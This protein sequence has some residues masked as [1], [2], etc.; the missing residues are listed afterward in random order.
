MTE[1]ENEL[2]YTVT[3]LIAAPAK[4]AF[5]FLADVT[6]IGGWALGAFDAKPLSTPGVHAGTSLYD[7]S[8]CAFAVDADERRLLVDYLVGSNAK[9]L[10]M[11]I[12][13]RIIPGAASGR[14]A[15]S[16]LVSMAAW[17]PDGFDERR[18]A[19]LK[20]FHDAEIHIVRDRVEK[21]WGK[22]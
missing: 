12:A 20:A 21:A 3:S 5:A 15:D 1:N 7:G 22:R 11:R 13:I 2:C 14:D 8:D 18:W 6:K 16:C 10:V 9:D 19:R 4:T 17:R